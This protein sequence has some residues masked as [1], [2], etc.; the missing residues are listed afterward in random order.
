MH[1]PFCQHTETKVIDSRLADDGSQV[2]RRR[3][4]MHCS[5][6][7]TT[8]EIVELDMPR[9]SKRDGRQCTFDENKIRLGCLR[10]LEKRPVHVAEVDRLVQR[11]VHQIQVRGEREISTAIIGDMVMLELQQLDPVAYVRFASI[12]RSFQ[13]VSE[14]NA[15]VQRLQTLSEVDTNEK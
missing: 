15:E 7:Y 1:C 12:Y 14:F 5:E 4:C 9:V 3:E 8:R 2:R 10:A 13:D 6:R 11:I